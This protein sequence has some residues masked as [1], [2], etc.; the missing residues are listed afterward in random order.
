MDWVPTCCITTGHQEEVTSVLCAP[1]EHPYLHRS[2]SVIHIEISY[3]WRGTSDTNPTSLRFTQLKPPHLP[4]PI[5]MEESCLLV[6]HIS[7]RVSPGE[8]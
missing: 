4:E 1:Y 7:W 2:L 6:I 3:P 8:G 5:F